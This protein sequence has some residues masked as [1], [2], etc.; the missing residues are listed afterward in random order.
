MASD[1]PQACLASGPH[2]N[3]QD[4]ESTDALMLGMSGKRKGEWKRPSALESVV[5]VFLDMQ[6][7]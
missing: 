3:S 7:C 1:S 5:L 2:L 6:K 4:V